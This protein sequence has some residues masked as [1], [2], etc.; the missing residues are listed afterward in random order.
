[1]S[2]II[3]KKGKEEAVKRRHP[4]VF[5]GAIAEKEE[6]LRDGDIV[7]VYTHNGK[8]AG[9]GHY[10]DSSIAV[11]IFSF[12][13]IEINSDFWKSRIEEAYNYRL[14]CG[15]A[16]KE[17]TNCFRLVFGES[18]N[19]PGLIIDWYNGHAVFQ[20]H[21]IGMHR[22]RNDFKNALS[23]VFG[24]QLKT[25]YDKSKESLP[26]NY[27]STI[28][29]E[30]VVGSDVETVVKENGNSFYVNWAE[31]QKTG[32]FL[33]QRENRRLLAE[34]CGGKKVLNAFSYTGGFSVYAGNAGAELVHSVDASKKAV[35]LADRN[36]A[37][38]NI[39]NHESFAEDVF[40][41]LKNK[42]MNYDIVILDPP[43][44]AKH[45]EAKHKAV[46]GY[47]NLNALA[48]KKMKP[49]S[50]LFTF[51]C[52]GVVEKNLFFNTITAAA[53]EA[54]RDIRILHYLNQPP[55]HPINPMHPESEYL[56]GLIVYVK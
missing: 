15:I 19:L 25:V 4:W 55:D 21:S 32:F 35:E 20:A 28:T 56:K 45:R 52:T 30:F 6:N 5:S 12:T 29:N 54:G 11:R 39:S 49:G 33:D 40:D 24:S 17:H 53:I 13:D 50:I 3:L 36:A 18:D 43:A 26:A 1:M 8:F 34:Y 10:Q 46:I 38:N 2:R 31:G 42:H 7:Q 16:G 27:A 37:L 22:Q 9:T 23:E 51:S 47:R 14:S 41:F 44:F 48:M